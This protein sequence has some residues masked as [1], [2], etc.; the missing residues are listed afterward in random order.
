MNPGPDK[1]DLMVVGSGLAGL[2]SALFA[3]RRGLSVSLCGTSGGT[4]LSSGL[5][6]LLGVHPQEQGRR[7]DDPWAGIRDLKRTHPDHPYAFLGQEEIRAALEE[8][9][10]FSDSR[11]HPFQ[12]RMERNVLVPTP[13]G[14]L[15]SSFL[16]PQSVWPGV[17]ALE[18]KAPTLIV[19]FHGL[20]G[21]SGAQVKEGLGRLWP[22]LETVRVPFPGKSGELYPLHL[23][24][25]LA[26]PEVRRELADSLAGLIHKVDY[27]GFPAI[28]GINRPPEVMAHLEELTQRRVFE[29]PTLPPGLPGLRLR[30]G[31]GAGL[32]SLG[33]KSY[34]GRLVLEARPLEGEGYQLQLGYDRPQETVQARAVVLATGRFL[35][36]GL[37][38]D[39][40]GVR[41]PLFGLR[42]SQPE[43]RR[44]W[45]AADFFNPRG[46]PLSRAGLRTDPDLRPLDE[47]G[48]PAR[49]C[50][51]AVGTI[52]AG[53]DWIR[54]KCGGGV[55]I[56]TAY[57][58]VNSLARELK[59]A[60]P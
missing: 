40:K 39:R 27:I 47:T 22:G 57:K 19:D 38:A 50:L 37:I 7:L 8:F 55:S 48:R 17:E 49:A 45:T 13:A 21:F 15:K 33:V 46:H 18:R 44:E 11:G 20:K 52:L 1:Y 34:S 51:H 26:R 28:L 58:A 43:N 29:I 30:A 60:Q 9:R 31:F 5:I 2:A 53:N 12:G 23:A 3:A 56:A 36:G 42:V 14:T 54:R 10:A 35:G 4:D 16:V 24:R 32:S 25:C 59:A 41:E 6:D